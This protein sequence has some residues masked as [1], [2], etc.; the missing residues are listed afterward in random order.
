MGAVRRGENG[1]LGRFEIF[2]RAAS[3]YLDRVAGW[4]LAA[5]MVLVV[6]NVVMRSAFKL[7][8]FG[9]YEYVGLLTALVIAL[10]LANCEVQ[11]GHIDISFLVERL[12]AGLRAAAALLAGTA[13]FCFWGAVSWYVLSYARTLAQ[14]G[15]VT[16]T[17][18]LPAGPFVAAVSAGLAV[19]SL[20]IL[21]K[22]A[23]VFIELK[24][25]N[26]R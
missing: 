23:G 10:S 19:Y 22:T 2:M 17:A 4:L 21:C 9:A 7:P 8:V 14:K 16:S 24:R 18:Q 5:V 13:G 11:N 6:A 25:G 15:Q 26:K 3:R 20:V 1:Q 12:P